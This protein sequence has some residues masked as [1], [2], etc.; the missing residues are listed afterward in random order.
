MIAGAT[1]LDGI[2]LCVAANEGVM[3]QTVD[4]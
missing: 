4:T 2:V 3:P 1:A